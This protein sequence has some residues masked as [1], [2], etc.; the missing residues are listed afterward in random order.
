MAYQ[1]KLYPDPSGKRVFFTDNFYTR[2]TLAKELQ[3]ITDNEAR[4]IGTVKFTNVDATNRKHLSE[5]MSMLKDAPR[6]SWCLVRAYDKIPDLE[7]LRRKHV[8]AEKKKPANQRTQFVAPTE[9]VA[10]N[11]G[12]IFWKD[13]K[14]VVFYTNDLASTPSRCILDSTSD[15]AVLCVRG[16]APLKRWTGNESLHRTTFMV[17][18][19]IVAYNMYMNSVDR[20]DQKRATNPTRR[21]E[22]RLHMSLFTYFLDMAALQAYSVFQTIRPRESVSFAEFKRSLCEDLVTP[23][24][25]HRKRPRIENEPRVIENI[26]GSNEHSHML[27]ENINRADINCYFCL[28]RGV[29]KKTIYG[30]M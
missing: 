16:L 29:K 26:L 5:A 8:A 24:R 6:G 30:C 3:G 4:L 10:E 22:Q 23:Y 12:Y 14:L 7:K 19:I 27:I 15:E 17:P 21:K 18:V 2:H 13:S 28:F 9:L 1:T 20:M 11:A 25:S